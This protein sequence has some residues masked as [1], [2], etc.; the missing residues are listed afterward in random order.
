MSDISKMSDTLTCRE[1]GKTKINFRN[2]FVTGICALVKLRWRRTLVLNNFIP[3]LLCRV[4]LKL[5]Q[6][7]QV[8]KTCEV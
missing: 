7:S 2:I 5:D 6:T 4:K 1:G 8:F 3:L